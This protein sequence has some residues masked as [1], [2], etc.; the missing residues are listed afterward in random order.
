MENKYFKKRT[1]WEIVLLFLS[2]LLL[3]YCIN[4]RYEWHASYPKTAQGYHLLAKSLGLKGKYKEAEAAAIKALAID[5]KFVKAY[6]D[7][8]NIY[9]EQGDLYKAEW[10]YRQALKYAGN[11]T[12]NLEV[13]YFDLGGMYTAKGDAENGWAYL[14]KAYE[15][16]SYIL[17]DWNVRPSLILS[18]VANNNKDG[19]QRYMQHKVWERMD[20]DLL[21]NRFEKV[22][23]DC[24][25]FLK[26]SPNSK[27]A[28]LF[29][30]FLASALIRAGRYKEAREKLN[31]MLNLSIP[32]KDKIWVK[33]NLA[34]SFYLQKDYAKALEEL[35]DIMDNYSDYKSPQL[36]HVYL[37]IADIYKAKKESREELKTLQKFIVMFP[38]SKL[39]GSARLRVSSIYYRLG[40][41][42]RGY[43]EYKKVRPVWY[44][45]LLSIVLVIGMAGLF[46]GFLALIRKFF[47]KS[48]IMPE[49]EKHL[50]QRLDIFLLLVF[51]YLIPLLI[52]LFLSRLFSVD[53]FSPKLTQASIRPMLWGIFLSEIALISICLAFLKKKYKLDN[54][55]LGFFSRGFK[56]NVILPAAAALTN[57]IAAF[58]ILAFIKMLGV[59]LPTALIEELV[60]TIFKGSTPFQMFLLFIIVGVI[61]PVTEEIIFR[62]FLYSAFKKYTTLLWSAILSAALFAILHFIFVL[63]PLFFI[64]GIILAVMYEKTRSIIPCMVTHALYN[65]SALVLGMIAIKYH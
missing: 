18:Y 20:K 33:R 56:F 52:T 35:S 3:V 34:Y 41:E 27:D 28:Y 5:N 26:D 7:L 1:I 51:L 30:E 24:E 48:E 47:P 58:L 54:V 36:E 2:L 50:F 25:Q 31:E 42:E 65:I 29:K 38:H 49:G 23:A 8:G 16:K 61:V 22:I 60:N 17:K 19:F 44:T 6:M 14:R 21:S 9:Q 12:I 63:L 55:S 57:V 53:C 39:I 64:V 40:D 62:V 13:I 4:Y 43:L 32:K 37:Q 59:Q 15:M 11:D 46:M 45:L 10:A